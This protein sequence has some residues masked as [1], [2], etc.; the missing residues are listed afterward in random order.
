MAGMTAL[1]AAGSETSREFRSV[2]TAD[3]RTGRLVRRN[4]PPA[5]AARLA[6]PR[7]AEAGAESA[8]GDT[9]VKLIDETAQRYALDPLLVHSVIKVESNYNPYAV[10]PKGAEGIMQLMPGTARRFEVANT[11]SASEN[12]EGGVRYLRYLLDTFRDQQLALA[13]YN[14]G[15]GA[16]MRYGSVPPYR[17]TA[18]YVRKVGERHQQARK[19]AAAKLSTAASPGTADA[20]PL[21]EEF[22]DERGVL[23]IRTV[24]R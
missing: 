19:S 18:D 15:E 23:H 11:F 22:V 8:A 10:S 13:A 3:I 4:I 17:E 9:L 1:Q 14:A 20:R 21:I 2:V 7:P 12:I 5:A 16:V 6:A 24:K